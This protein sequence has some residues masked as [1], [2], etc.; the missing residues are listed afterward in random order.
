[1]ASVRPNVLF[2]LTDQWRRQALSCNGD[3]LV[4][5]PHLDRLAVDG[6]NFRRCYATRIHIRS[7][8]KG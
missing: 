2:V 7:A 8:T 5:T 6:V 4:R 3:P 1:M